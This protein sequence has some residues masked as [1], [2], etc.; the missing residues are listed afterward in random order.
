MLGQW[1]AAGVPPAEAA[2]SPQP[3]LE[4][5]TPQGSQANAKHTDEGASEGR[6]LLSQFSRP[7]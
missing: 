5:S 1:S 7:K 4:L 6:C 3:H 2:L